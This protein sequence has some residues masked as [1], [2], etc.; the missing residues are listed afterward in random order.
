MAPRQH[1]IIEPPWCSASKSL[2]DRIDTLM[3]RMTLAEKL[4]QLR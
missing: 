1:A 2:D 4:G 3:A